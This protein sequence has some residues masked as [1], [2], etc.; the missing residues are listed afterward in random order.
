MKEEYVWLIMESLL[1]WVFSSNFYLISNCKLVVMV[2]TRPHFSVG[3][4]LTSGG[5][6]SH[7]KRIGIEKSKQTHKTWGRQIK[8]I[9]GKWGLVMTLKYG[10]VPRGPLISHLGVQFLETIPAPWGRQKSYHSMISF[11]ETFQKHVS[12]RKAGNSKSYSIFGWHWSLALNKTMIT[13]STRI[14]VFKGFWRHS[15]TGA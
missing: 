4:L 1:A 8:K 6:L 7:V 9:W 13:L 14:M 10:L 11:Q 3:L 15:S 12:C 5:L 2:M